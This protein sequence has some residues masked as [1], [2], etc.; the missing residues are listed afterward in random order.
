MSEAKAAFDEREVVTEGYQRVVK[1]CYYNPQLCIALWS[2]FFRVCKKLD[3]SK[4]YIRSGQ[5]ELERCGYY[6]TGD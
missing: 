5:L 6:W 4:D 1:Y 2:N 3:F